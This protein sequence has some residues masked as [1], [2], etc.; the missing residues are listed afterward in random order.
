MRWRR[1]GGGDGAR[2]RAKTAA[3]AWLTLQTLTAS[4]K[5]RAQRQRADSLHAFISSFLSSLYYYYFGRSHILL[6]FI[7]IIY[8]IIYY[9]YIAVCGF[10]N[11]TCHFS[12]IVS[13]LSL[14]AMTHH[15]SSTRLPSLL[16]LLRDRPFPWSIVSSAKGIAALEYH[17]CIQAGSER[18]SSSA[19]RLPC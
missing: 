7:F 11:Q 15:T 8:I 2:A 14:H 17:F 4:A 16:S 19:V 10:Q 3:R 18:R 5:N 1:C 6:F 12:F 9:I 13:S